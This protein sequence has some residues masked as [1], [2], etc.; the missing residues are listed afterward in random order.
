MINNVLIAWL[1]TL[2]K[3]NGNK[4]IATRVVTMLWQYSTQVILSKS[5]MF[6]WMSEE[7]VSGRPHPITAR[8]CNVHIFPPCHIADR[9]N[10]QQDHDNR[11]LCAASNRPEQHRDRVRPVVHAMTALKAQLVIRIRGSER[12][13]LSFLVCYKNKN[14]VETGLVPYFFFKCVRS[15]R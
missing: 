10:Q 2:R 9:F 11:H 5:Y 15:V 14:I 12:C 13:N 3:R 4:E 6:W 7:Y 1:R 8:L